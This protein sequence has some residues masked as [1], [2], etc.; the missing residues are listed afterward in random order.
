MNVR[1]LLAQSLAQGN[2]AWLA[3]AKNSWMNPLH[4][5]TIKDNYSG[6]TGGN[7][8]VITTLSVA[9]ESAG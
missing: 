2:R 7:R 8:E 3:G 9:P 4:H 6:D 5:E 1:A